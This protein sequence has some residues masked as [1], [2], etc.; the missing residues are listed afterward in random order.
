MQRGRATAVFHLGD[1]PLHLP[2]LAEVNHVSNVTTGI[3]AS[4]RLFGSLR[5][6]AVDQRGRRLGNRAIMDVNSFT[7]HVVMAK[8]SCDP[9]KPNAERAVNREKIWPISP[10]VL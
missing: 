8:S 2:P 1:E 5:T 6:V 9:L 3:R 10:L 7:H 4:V